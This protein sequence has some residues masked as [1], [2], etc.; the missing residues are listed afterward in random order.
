ML[1]RR[2]TQNEG[3]R[4]EAFVQGIVDETYAFVWPSG[5]PP[6]DAVDW[7]NSW[8]ADIDGRIAAVMLT[9]AD[10][11]DDLWVHGENRNTGIGSTLLSLAE[12]DI[13][14]RGHS[15]A[16]LRVVDG[17]NRALA[18]YLKHGWIIESQ[19]AHERLPIT[20]IT[21]TKQISVS[22]QV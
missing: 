7:T 16:R 3:R 14:G 19:K 17:N 20:M 6:I 8:I 12:S 4:I 22:N 15:R 13:A 2:P 11:L 10:W 9:S 21:L 18:F 5:A 1:I